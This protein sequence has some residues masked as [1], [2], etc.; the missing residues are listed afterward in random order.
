MSL[1]DQYLDM[2]WFRIG[3]SIFTTQ[4]LKFNKQF[5]NAIW[6]KVNLCEFEPDKTQ[7]KLLR[8]NN[9]FQVKIKKFT[10]SQE[11]EDLYQLYKTGIEFQPSQSLQKLLALHEE[12]QIFHTYQA[13]VYDGDC[14]IACGFFDKGKKSVA[15]ICAFYHPD[16]K[17]YSLGKYL[18]LQK[19]LYAKNAGYT[20][21][22][23]GYLV[24][25]YAPFEYKRSLSKTA[26]S[27]YHISSKL[28]LPMAK[29]EDTSWPLENMINSLTSLQ[30]A[31]AKMGLPTE[32]YYYD[33]FDA[34]LI[35]GFQHQTL[36]DYPVFLM[37]S[38]FSHSDY[39]INFVFDIHLQQYHAILCSHL[40][41][42]PDAKD[43]PGYYAA[44]VLRQEE[45]L[46]SE[47]EVAD[48][49]LHFRKQAQHESL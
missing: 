40:W 38:A 49:V 36:V 29:L 14:L 25:H 39:Q 6:L 9:G 44:S 42:N 37:S 34:K 2:G 31:L 12:R 5:Y 48:F 13:E 28:W 32:L 21:F 26:M 1:L 19:M 47:I 22:Y 15:G 20:F 45:I 24:P 30:E 8:L 7:Q 46:F 11:Q 17:K 43:E 35:P 33:Y 10:L 23:P 3:Q 16:Y 18:I 41:C 4:F 27:F